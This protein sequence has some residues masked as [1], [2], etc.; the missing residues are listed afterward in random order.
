MALFNDYD[1]IPKGFYFD[2]QMNNPLTSVT[3]HK[4]M[5]PGGSAPR[6]WKD[7]PT[8]DPDAEYDTTPIARSILLDDF[9]V[10]IGNNFQDFGGDPIGST[11]TSIAGQLGPY[12]RYGG[13]LINKIKSDTKEYFEQTAG[14]GW[15]TSNIRSGLES[16]IS[17]TDGMLSG[18][19]GEGVSVGS[20][21]DTVKDVLKGF[22]AGN[23]LI[24]QG[25]RFKYYSGSDISYG[26][27]SM[28]FY[29][30]SEL[31]GGSWISVYDQLN[32]LLPYI[33]GKLHNV[34]S[35]KDPISTFINQFAKWQAPPA[36]YLADMVDVD[37]VQKGT[38]RMIIGC[39]YCVESLVVQSASLRFSKQMVKN[40]KSPGKIDPMY[41]EITLNLTPASKSSDESL[42]RFVSGEGTTLRREQKVESTL[43]S[44]ISPAGKT[45]QDQQI[46]S[47]KNLI[48]L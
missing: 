40:P 20:I 22:A 19:F 10:N 28:R 33:V 31:R 23:A 2:Q 29:Y 24:V 26:N 37:R 17:K 21:T 14:G 36:G 13:Q 32:P 15:A 8:S 43:E 3:L 39:Y 18:I 45:K 30:F 7:A 1:S 27:L 16:A 9:E 35:D 5:D 11:F 25:T 4:N 46:N 42:R 41:C 38:L 44:I 12:M 6:F 48:G 34:T 47:M